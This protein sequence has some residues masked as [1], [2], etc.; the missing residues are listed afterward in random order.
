M[1]VDFFSM[2][3][4]TL[5]GRARVAG[6]LCFM[7]LLIEV[8]A[9]E[10]PAVA[11]DELVPGALAEIGTSEIGD[12]STT[13]KLEMC[14]PSVLWNITF[15]RFSSLAF[16]MRQLTSQVGSWILLIEMFHSGLV[17]WRPR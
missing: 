10:L 14:D 1:L 15:S 11:L 7:A 8:L 2:V 17:R 9:P 6:A 4:F 13:S 12:S 5:V 16:M 3:F